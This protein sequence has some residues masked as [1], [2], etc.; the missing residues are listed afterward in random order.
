MRT[1]LKQIIIWISISMIS[2]L[3]ILDCSAR[4]SLT[5]DQLPKVDSSLG[6]GTLEISL[7]NL[8]NKKVESIYIWFFALMDKELIEIPSNEMTKVQTH[9]GE[10]DISAPYKINLPP[11]EYYARLEALNA[12]A[13]NHDLVFPFSVLFG[14][15][16]DIKKAPKQAI[17]SNFKKPKCSVDEK[18]FHHCS[19]IFIKK[20]TITKIIIRVQKE[21]PIK[22]ELGMGVMNTT[23]LPIP[24]P[25]AVYI[26]ESPEVLIEVQNPK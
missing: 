1:N 7:E 19:T 8:E 21:V 2:F 23:Q 13:Y 14:Y 10:L 4:I 25:R 11:G 26:Q 5:Y 3:G 16:F 12:P 18:F 9:D 15:R 6:M 20:D 22:T 24:Y 17:A